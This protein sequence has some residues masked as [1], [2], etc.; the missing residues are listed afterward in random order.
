MNFE[1]VMRYA[2]TSTL[3]ATAEHFGMTANT[4]G[5][6]FSRNGTSY[7]QI[8]YDFFTKFISENSDMTLDELAR[9]LKCDKR[10]IWKYRGI[11]GTHKDI[12]AIIQYAGT[13]SLK[14]TADHFG[15]T[16]QTVGELF[17]AHGTCY[18]RI[19]QEHFTK[20]IR[21]NPG[22]TIEE[23]ANN[24]RCAEHTVKKYRRML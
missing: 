8:R 15:V 21:E 10:T 16:T 13:A 4:V 6:L 20:F 3:K 5:L 17:I 19:R 14:E 9:C 12:D 23:L 11:N 24:L 1:A 22:M 18:T 2:Q 7:T